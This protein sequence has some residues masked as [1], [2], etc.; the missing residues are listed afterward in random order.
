[1]F[2]VKK[3]SPCYAKGFLSPIILKRSAGVICLNE[4]PLAIISVTSYAC[5]QMVLSKAKEKIFLQNARY[6]RPWYIGFTAS[7]LTEISYEEKSTHRVWAFYF[8]FALAGAF[9]LS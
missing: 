8:I 9:H 7:T 6:H 4:K 3:T 5:C 1:M 2:H